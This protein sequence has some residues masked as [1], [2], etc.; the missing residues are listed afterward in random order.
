MI[1]NMEPPL[2]YVGFG[3]TEITP[4]LGTPLFGYSG[5]VRAAGEVADGLNATA[6]F[7]RSGDVSAVL[8]SLDWGLVDEDE[9]T[10]IRALVSAKTGIAGENVTVCASHT[11]SAPQT[12]ESWGWGEKNQVY[13]DG[14]RET[15]AQAVVFAQDGLQPV[16]VG[17]GTTPTQTG[18]NRREVAADGSMGLGFQE[19][20]PRDETLT[21]VRFEGESGAVAQIV[22]LAAHPTARGIDPAI[23]RD[24]PGVMADRIEAVTHCPVFFLNGAFGDVAPRTAVG[25]AGGDGAESAREVGLRAANDA[26]P[27]WRGLK[28]FR[29]MALEVTH[30]E[31]ELPYAPLEPLEEALRQSEALQSFAGTIGF[32]AC[33]KKYWTAVCQAHREAPRT[34]RLFRQTLTKIGPLVIVPFA[35]EIFSE[36]GLRL[37]KFSPFA[38]TLCAGTANGSHGY[39]VT[40]EARARGGYEIWV[41]RAYGAYLLANDIDDVLVRENL[42]LL[43][44]GFAGA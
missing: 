10:Q 16:S 39:Y 38:H 40:R 34:G 9:T 13:L 24:W 32:E 2:L 41:G 44:D 6:L 23:S 11:H 28:D 25:G 12:V 21:V 30:G 4:P 43:N 14:V 31:F 3:R 22:H 42:L 19:W 36:I 29:T 26:I 5:G 7:L 1:R 17:I 37:K 33:M 27:V 35:G 20:G 15:I 8:V 18:I